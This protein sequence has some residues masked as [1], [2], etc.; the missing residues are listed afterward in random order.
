M[1]IVEGYIAMLTQFGDF[2]NL[3]KFFKNQQIWLKTLMVY[4]F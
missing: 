2:P 1:L 3:P 4:D